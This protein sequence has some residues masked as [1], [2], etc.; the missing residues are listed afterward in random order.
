MSPGI[1]RVTAN[2]DLVVAGVLAVAAAVW[3]NSGATGSIALPLAFAL[4]LVLPG[5]V[6][7]TLAYANRGNSGDV[8]GWTLVSL[9]ERL[10]FS[11]GGSLAVLPVLAIVTYLSPL[12]LAPSAL[13]SVVSGYVLLGAVATALR[14]DRQPRGA[15]RESESVTSLIQG[16]VGAIVRFPRRLSLLDG[17]LVL[18]VVLAVSTLGVAVAVPSHGE[19][20]TDLHLLT[21]QDG[22]LVANEYPDELTEGESVP[23]TVGVTNEEHE[24]AAYTV[25]AELQRVQVEG[26]SVVVA[27]KRSV[28]RHDL[29]LEHGET[30]RQQLDVQASLTGENLRLAVYLYRGE[31]PG[32]P[33][34]ESA[35]RNAYIWIDVQP[36]EAGTQ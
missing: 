14:R 20:T 29:Q 13:V 9:T 26:R 7:M 5:Y 34:M 35:Y 36:A 16:T 1:E 25:V 4:L 6:T 15:N 23:L 17:V 28:G 8:R 3:S 11:L 22:R 21:E 19:A 31:A 33:T 12:A 30:W 18:S 2:R 24:Q 27:D 32:N 10:A